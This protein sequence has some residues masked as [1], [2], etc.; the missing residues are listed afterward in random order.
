MAP[1]VRRCLNEDDPQYGAVAVKGGDNRW[2]VMNP[3][4]GGHW[5]TDEEVKDWEPVPE[6]QRAVT[7][8]EAEDHP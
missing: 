7:T 4:N 2:G 5:A 3:V 8:P 1:E 6:A